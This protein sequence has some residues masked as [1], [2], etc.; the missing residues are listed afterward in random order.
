[1]EKI[2]K[3]K[4]VLIFIAMFFICAATVRAATIIFASEEASYDNTTSNLEATNVQDAIDELY[5]KANSCTKIDPALLETSPVIN[6]YINLNSPEVVTSGNGLYSDNS[7]GFTRFI[8]KGT[9]A[10]TNNYIY[11]KENGE[12][13]LYRIYSIES[14]GTV[15]V[16]RDENVTSMNFDVTDATRRKGGY[17]TYDYCNAWA[18][19]TGFVNGTYTGDV[20]GLT[21]NTGD[22]SIKEYIDN[23]YSATLDDYSKIVSKTWNISGTTRN[24][25]TLENAI[26]D[27]KKST[28]NGKIALLTASEYVRANTN[29]S[30]CG[31]LANLYSNNS[32]C[33]STNYLVRSSYWWLLSPNSGNRS[34]VL[35]VNSSSFVNLSNVSNSYGVRPSFYLCSGLTYSGKG[36]SS[37]PYYISGGSCKS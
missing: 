27:E 2:F 1:M 4:K 35:Y 32:T 36:T 6:T 37:E 18:A 8:Y 17:C 5:G 3:N 31:T 22:S 7:E 25:D 16:I 33:K 30:S 24:R 14:D 11:I 29:T 19:M 28:W 13:V 21:G 20:A 12:N 23:T 34:T 10:G 15:K 26:A 9:S